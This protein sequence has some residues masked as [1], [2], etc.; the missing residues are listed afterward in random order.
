[1]AYSSRFTPTN[2]QRP[3][4]GYHGPA[5]RGHGPA[6]GHGNERGPE[7]SEISHNSHGRYAEYDQ[8]VW[9]PQEQYSDGDRGYES[10][11]RGWQN[12][13][14]YAEPSHQKPRIA[15]PRNGNEHRIR[16][17][18]PFPGSQVQGEDYDQGYE[19]YNSWRDEKQAHYQWREQPQSRYHESQ[20][21]QHDGTG[22]D[23]RQRAALMSN[24]RPP[25]NDSNLKYGSEEDQ[26]PR[27]LNHGESR[28]GTDGRNDF[29]RS[30]KPPPSSHA[31]SI[32][33]HSA[34][35]CKFS[36]STPHPFV[37]LLINLQP[38]HGRRE[39]WRTSNLQ[40][41][42][43]GIILSQRFHP[44]LRKVVRATRTVYT[45]SLRQA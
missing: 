7:P 21:H 25:R 13:R 44:N 32:N 31:R 22:F 14:S 26:L 20:D 39:S 43:H 24:P 19:N 4:D 1:M 11:Q 45:L 12:G 41:H 30:P 37:L 34:S 18:R 42:F 6:R 40:K 33:P 17:Q 28:L 36:V 15:A 16:Q 35:S 2:A 9:S 23:P 27:Y 5:Q 38:H 29:S 3:H 8:N 10:S